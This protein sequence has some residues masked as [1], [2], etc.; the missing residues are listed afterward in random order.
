MNILR[1]LANIFANIELLRRWNAWYHGY[2]HHW[3]IIHIILLFSHSAAITRD[4]IHKCILYLHV[5]Q[6]GGRHVSFYEK[7]LCGMTCQNGAL[8]L[9][10][11]TSMW[12]MSMWN[13]VDIYEEC[14]VQW[15]IYVPLNV[16]VECRH[17][18]CGM[19][20]Q[21]GALCLCGMTSKHV[22][23]EYR[24]YLCG[25]SRW[26][27]LSIWSP[28]CMWNDFSMWKSVWCHAYDLVD[29]F[30]HIA[31]QGGTHLGGNL[32]CCTNMS[33]QCIMYKTQRVFACFCVSHMSESW[34]TLQYGKLRVCL[35]SRAVSHLG[36]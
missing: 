9:C 30:S 14:H 19:S 32:L 2:T 22:Y 17:Y 15:F 27:D 26:N 5:A 29:F 23:V 6:Q 31:Q 36:S 18:L 12:N 16:Y 35:K 25:M 11:M 28:I 4:I 20:C 21:Y 10:E 7:C 13:A 1:E 24:Q 33:L 34:H 8:C 3:Y